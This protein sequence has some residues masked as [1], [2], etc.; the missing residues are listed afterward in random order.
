MIKQL[1]ALCITSRSLLI[2]LSNWLITVFLVMT[3]QFICANCVF[4]IFLF[5]MSYFLHLFLGTSN[6][7]VFYIKFQHWF[8]TH[9]AV[10]M[11]PLRITF[12]FPAN[13]KYVICY[14]KLFSYCFFGFLLFS[15]LIRKKASNFLRI[16]LFVNVYNQ[17]LN[18]KQ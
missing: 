7:M 6:I 10:V 4:A 3:Q 18:K 9:M 11:R 2:L 5:L 15:L 8:S 16:S 14:E 12:T 1:S 13:N 17:L